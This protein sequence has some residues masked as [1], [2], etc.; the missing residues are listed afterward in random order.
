VYGHTP[1]SHPEW[2]DGTIDVDTRCVLGG[3][4][5]ALGWPELELVSVPARERHAESARP[6]DPAHP[7]APAGTAAGSEPHRSRP[8]T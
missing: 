3:S 2:H 1:V 5:T 7:E 8:R 6:F 4:L